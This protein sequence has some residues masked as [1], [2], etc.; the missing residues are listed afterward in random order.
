MF[1]SQTFLARKGPLGTVW[2]AAHLQ[3]R[4]KKSHYTS[5]DIS[6]TVDRIMFPEVPIALRMSGHL[7]LGVVRIYSKKVDYLFQD[8]NVV[9]NVLRKAFASI[10]LNLPE[11]ARQ[12]PVQSITLPDKFDLD[13]LELDD[14]MYNDGSPDNHLRSQEEI[15][16]TDQ[17]P[18]GRD[19]YIAISFDEDIVMM[20]LPYPQVVPYSDVRPMEEDIPM[21]PAIS[22]NEDFPHPDARLSDDQTPRKFPHDVAFRDSGL[23]NQTE[24]LDIHDNIPQDLPER[25]ILRDAVHDLGLEQLPPVFPDRG[26]EI[27]ETNRSLKQIT[28]E[29]DT[30]SPILDDNLASGGQSLPFQQHT[31][32]PPSAASLGSAEIFDMPVSFSVAR[33]LSPG[34]GI[35]RSTPPVQQ[36]K[37][38]KRKRKQLFDESTVLTNKFMKK[39]LEDTS[40]LL[41]K[42]RDVPCSALGMWKS[43]NSL[44][45][46][47]VFHQP[48]L[49]GLCMDLFNF[50]K[51]EYMTSKP[52]L[53]LSEETFT[54]P[55]VPASPASAKEALPEPRVAESPAAS[56]EVVPEFRVAQSPPPMPELDIEIERPR[57]AEHFDGSSFLPEFVPSQAGFTPSP[58]RR[59]DFTPATTMETQLLPTPDLAV[60]TGTCTSEFKRSVAFSEER[61]GLENTGLSDI[62][63]LMHS[64]EADDLHFLEADNNTPTGSQATGGV[65]SLSV[66]TR[67]VA[68][69]LKRH[70]PFSPTLEALSGDLTLNKTLEG[71]TRKL[72]ARMFFEILVLKS[73]GLVDVQQEVPYDDISLKLT[74]TLSKVGI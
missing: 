74:P 9:L 51:N 25:E 3:H 64:A 39:T 50:S 52:H 41:R 60:S 56:T 68:Q 15:T 22:G 69:Y 8:C 36:P 34:L 1:Y 23:S 35:I 73:Y 70:S 11:D 12:A 65:D 59:C 66:R 62:P 27:G 38:R 42:K 48:L 2:C 13:T 31:E 61:L 71:R 16:L 26:D 4:L 28:N 14:E 18:I 37:A 20:D 54:D 32:P 40:D 46:D 21:Q 58:L 55:R 10:D 7:L 49:T 43:K 29:K 30:L 63:S 47:Q 5:T 45:K 6:S 57:D 33:D 67:A 53:V 19:P 17:I 24:M 44:K 72:C